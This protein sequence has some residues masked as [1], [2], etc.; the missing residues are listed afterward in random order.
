[1]VAVLSVAA[2][3]W[4]GRH[5]GH[6]P[7]DGAKGMAAGS[8]PRNIRTRRRAAPWRQK[9]SVADDG[10]ISLLKLVIAADAGAVVD[11]EH[12]Q[13]A[14]S[15]RASWTL[16]E[17]VRFDE[18]GILSHPDTYPILRFLEVPEIKVVLL[19]NQATHQWAS[20]GIQRFHWRR[21]CQR[22]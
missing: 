21:D 2:I 5:Q 22:P 14:T 7:I 20:A 12:G 19:D 18:S 8:G 17:Q 16:H 9:V 4:T 11:P 13:S 6:G 10:V 3:D 15:R 1:M